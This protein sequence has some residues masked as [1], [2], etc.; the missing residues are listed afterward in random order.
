MTELEEKPHTETEKAPRGSKRP[1]GPFAFLQHHPG[2]FVT[3]GYLFLTA[4]GIIYDVLFFDIFHVPILNFSQ[5]SDFVLAGFRQPVLFVLFFVSVL[6]VWRIILKDRKWRAKSVKYRKAME[7]VETK[8]WFSTWLIYPAF[9][10]T[11]FFC[12]TEVFAKY[13][14]SN[15]MLGK[16]RAI[17]I[18]LN[19]TLTDP[20]P[21]L[22]EVTSLLLGSNSSYIFLFSPKDGRVRIIP[23][24]SIARM[25][26]E[27]ESRASLDSGAIP[28]T[29]GEAGPPL[30]KHS[31]HSSTRVDPRSQP[32]RSVAP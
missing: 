6:M 12:T 21:K 23:I 26:M 27:P 18:E 5:P 3:I 10:C 24:Q 7:R 29:D 22:K 2:L 15:L 32:A 31:G 8:M 25:Q 19:A 1:T 30:V 9:V 16:G 14:A 13:N 17:S 11:Y 28:S 4:I 20:N